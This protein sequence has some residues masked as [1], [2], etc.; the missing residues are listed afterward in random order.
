MRRI[1][2]AVVLT[3]AL[4][5]ASVGIV[6]AMSETAYGQEEE[7][8]QQRTLWDNIKASGTVG[9]IQIL[10]SV[11]GLALTLEDF[12]SIRREKMIPPHL[13]GELESLFD[14]EEYEEAMDVCDRE[15]SVLSRVVGAALAKVGGGYAR[16]R[17]AAEGV[18]DEETLV[19][20]QKI[21]YISLLA[22]VEPMLGLLGT[23]QGMIQAFDK[24]AILKTA[25]SP[26]DLAGSIS[27]ALVTTAIG[28]TVAI[29]LTAVYMF[30]RNRVM[31]L[32]QE[33]NAITVE[34]L[35]R[36]RKSE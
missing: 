22:S 29:P 35:E 1:G 30:L 9:L 4:G 13:L 7:V 34:L 21:S 31:K 32:T 17:E 18:G 24:I 36:F 8:A 10:L 2:A 20:V 11:V 14:E 27:L 15:D 25:V 23:V 19:L 6:S 16:M 26:S 5:F 12:V 28:L 33:A 3:L